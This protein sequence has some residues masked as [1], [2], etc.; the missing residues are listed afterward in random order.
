MRED[1][2]GF[3]D[4]SRAKKAKDSKYFKKAKTKAEDYI[5]NP[6]KLNGLFDKASKKANNKKEQLEVVWTHLSASF[7]LIKA[8]ANGTYRKIPW[9]SVAMIVASIVYFV[10]PIDS[11]P[12]FI[13]FFG[14]LDDVS[15][16]GWM[17]KTFSSDIDAFVEWESSEK[18]NV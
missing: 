6:G 12:D 5:S 4:A 17:V 10:W 15:L 7:R 8:Y 18:D 11:L 3:N 1:M 13:P 2:A 9:R 14:Y 16:L